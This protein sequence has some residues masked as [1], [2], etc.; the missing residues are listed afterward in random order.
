MHWCRQATRD[1]SP[2]LKEKSSKH[3]DITETLIRGDKHADH[4]FRLQTKM[5]VFSKHR[6]SRSVFGSS[7][8]KFMM[9]MWI[10]HFGPVAISESSIPPRTCSGR[11]SLAAHSQQ[12]YNHNLQSMGTSSLA[13]ELRTGQDA[14]LQAR[15]FDD[16]ANRT[17]TFVWSDIMME[18]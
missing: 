2:Q 4:I 15:A 14:H 1:M 8:L 6:L 17:P 18:T 11:G 10:R 13:E 7:R 9:H 5:A 3:F 12:R 16:A